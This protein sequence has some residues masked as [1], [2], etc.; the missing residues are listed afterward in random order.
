M[1]ATCEMSSERPTE[2]AHDS[3][4]RTKRI[5]SLVMRGEDRRYPNKFDKAN[6]APSQ[7]IET[8]TNAR[9]RRSNS[10]WAGGGGGLAVENKNTG[11]EGEKSGGAGH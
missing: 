6:S 8:V 9:N 11:P 4:I 5:Q 1:Q 2:G 3:L 10:E 7:S